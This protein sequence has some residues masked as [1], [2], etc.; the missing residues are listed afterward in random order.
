MNRSEVSESI[1]K[2]IDEQV[3]AIV[4]QCYEE[5]LALVQGQREAMDQLVELLIE[6]ETMDGDEFR[7][8]LSTFTSVPEKERFVP[9]LN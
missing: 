6:K 8:V 1:S 2:Q 4:M 5:T 9:V 7:E 3:R